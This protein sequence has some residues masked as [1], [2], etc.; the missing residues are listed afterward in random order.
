MNK[1]ILMVLV[2]M[3]FSAAGFGQTTIDKKESFFDKE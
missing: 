2:L 3:G 1:M